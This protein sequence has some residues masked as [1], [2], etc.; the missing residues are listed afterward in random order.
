MYNENL[1][2]TT[3]SLKEV[4]PLACMLQNTKV[5]RIMF[6]V[7]YPYLTMEDGIEWIKQVRA[8]GLVT[9]E[10]LEMIAH[11]NAEKFLGLKLKA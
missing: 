8:S 3:S 2:F 7:D 6:A 9:E 10:Q 11:G 4:A 5:E 1:W